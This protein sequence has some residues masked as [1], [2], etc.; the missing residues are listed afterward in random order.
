[1]TIT[2]YPK[3]EYVKCLSWHYVTYSMVYDTFYVTITISSVIIW[4]E[5]GFFVMFLWNSCLYLPKNIKATG[6]PYRTKEMKGLQ[7]LPE[8]RFIY[9]LGGDSL[10][11]LFDNKNLTPQKEKEDKQLECWEGRSGKSSLI[12][13][14]K[15]TLRK[16]AKEFLSWTVSEKELR[17][18]KK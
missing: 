7:P 5:S 4:A 3:Q 15:M 1:M 9:G 12:E 11:A 6:L 16:A 2:S 10:K 8:Q 17:T 18:M 14:R 13:Y